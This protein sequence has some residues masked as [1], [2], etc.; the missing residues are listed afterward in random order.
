VSELPTAP[1]KYLLATWLS[2]GNL[3]IVLVALALMALASTVA[4]GRFAERQALARSALAASSAR[5]FFHRL[6][7][8]NLVAARTLAD[9]P[10]L[11]RLLGDPA[12]PG[13]ALFLENYCREMRATACVVS[14]S[15]GI[16]A[17]YGAAGNWPEIAAAP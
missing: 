8:S 4:V 6:G 2:A 15:Q 5:E 10:T 17:A 11:V 14:N 7:E 12:G 9:R 16:I 1:R 13:L 3:L